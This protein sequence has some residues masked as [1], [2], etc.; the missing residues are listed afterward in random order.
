MN[1]YELICQYCG[2]SWEINYTPKERIFCTRCKD[3]DIV[4]KDIAKERIDYYSGAR[5]FPSEK[6]AN[7]G[8]HGYPWSNGG[9]D[10]GG[11]D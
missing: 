4:A 9:W 1:K 5:Q 11:I 6:E 7:E 2:N 10:P 3:P 8:D